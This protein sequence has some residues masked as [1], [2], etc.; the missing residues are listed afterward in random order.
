[1]SSP[2]GPIRLALLLGLG[3]C[4]GLPP[5]TATPP[6]RLPER[7][8]QEDP[9]PAE[10]DSGDEELERSE[11]WGFVLVP[12]LWVP[13]A[14]GTGDT[15]TTPPLDIDL[16]GGFD[17][18]LPL[19]FEAYSPDRTFTVLLEGLYLR[20]RGDEGLLETKTEGLMIEGG[21]GVALG[22]RRLWSV[23]AG[24]RYVDVSYEASLGS[25]M[26][27]ASGDWVD[28]WIGTLG[29]VPLGGRWSGRFRGDIG[30]F[31]VGSEL[32]WQAMALLRADFGRRVGIELG[33]RAISLS[34]RE[35]D[36][37]YDVTYHGPILRLAIGI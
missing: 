32:T 22:D 21:F 10:P 4:A 18:A 24:A 15:G 34:F 37:E 16:F 9:A 23:L 30:G 25:V 28:P 5:R 1:M 11:R 8:R 31:G 33:Y 6:A 13:S 36:F 27:E 29:T 12:Y 3:A 20:L 19:A 14:D 17:A 26:G 7:A 2:V 35:P